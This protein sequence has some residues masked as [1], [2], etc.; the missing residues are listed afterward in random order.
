MNNSIYKELRRELKSMATKGRLTLENK[1]QWHH[2]AFKERRHVGHH[3]VALEWLTFHEID[4]FDAIGYVIEQ[5][6][7][8]FDQVKLESGDVSP[9]KIVN[10]LVYYA[11]YEALE[12][13]EDKLE[14]YL[15]AKAERK[16][17]A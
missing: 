12:C 10:W 1:E 7:E 6:R 5:E 17:A 8:M 2:I 3:A 14:S 4:A 9:D 13:M 16:A 15:Q 11:G